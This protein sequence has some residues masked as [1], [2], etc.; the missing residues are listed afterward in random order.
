MAITR[1]QKLVNLHSAGKSTNNPL[2]AEYLEYGEIAVRH[3]VDE[4]RIYTKTAN[5][6]YATFLDETGVD[7]A[8]K[9]VTD[10][11]NSNVSNLS[12]ATEAFKT[13]V[14]TN[15][16]TK[17]DVESA[18]TGASG[19][20]NSTISDLS[21]SVISLES[22]HET[23]S[24][25]FDN[26]KQSAESDIDALKTW[27]GAAQENIDSLLEDVESIMGETGLIATAKSEAIE[28]ATKASSAYTDTKFATLEGV[29]EAH[30]NKFNHISGLVETHIANYNIFTGETNTALE[31]ITKTDGLIATA[32]FEAIEAATKASSAYTDAEIEKV[33][34]DVD[35]NA[36]TIE[37]LATK[38]ELKN[39]TDAYAAYT[40]TTNEA[41]NT[42]I[43]NSIRDAKAE[44]YAS[45]NS[46]TNAEISKVKN[47]D[48]S[49]LKKAVETLNGDADEVGSVKY[50]VDSAI[51][52]VVSGAP[53]SFDTLKEIA[54]WIANDSGVTAAVIVTDIEGLKNADK[55]ISTSL[56]AVS[57]HSVTLRNDFDIH[58]KSASDTYATK[59]EL[60]TQSGR[61]DTV[62]ASVN[63][64]IN[65]TI[66]NAISD[67]KAAV[68]A[69]ANSYTNAEIAKVQ[70]VVDANAETIS[71]LATKTEL[72]TQS[73]RVDTVSASV[74]TII[75]TTIPNSIRDAKAEVYASAN[76]YTNAEI[77]KVKNEE[78]AG[79]DL[80]IDALEA[81]SG[82]TNSAV[83]GADIENTA[84][85]KITV[86]KDDTNKLKFNFD[87]MVI[88]CGT[89]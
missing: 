8:I 75:N 30:A 4:A 20:I 46:Y 13:N 53:E 7:T 52:L 25:N 36:K 17:S 2:S 61:V 28:A 72:G 18:V 73:G 89:F 76:S 16:A 38:A 3:H 86:I 56:S 11:I 23:L 10:T 71:T 88:D 79:L 9:N 12:A 43:P 42:T 80:R 65:T 48:I 44:V 35:A 64:I 47:E 54:D 77:S 26:F 85:N 59:T 87:D 51:A 27:S 68:Y 6:K 83:Q 5:D 22:K 84:N 57:S 21:G 50:T 32:K 34:K 60:G 14:E 69:S 58:V 81:I 40:A 63:T 55:T 33:Q 31:N 1:K 67:A 74:N 15:Y 45:A 70:K 37:T 24:D 39:H 62:S 41:I 49:P 29:V 66:P 82:L 19:N 78:I